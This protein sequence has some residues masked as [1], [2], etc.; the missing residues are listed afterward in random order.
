MDVRNFAVHFK[1]QC[2]TP[3]PDCAI[4]TRTQMAL[5]F[6]NQALEMN[7]G[8]YKHGRTTK[9]GIPQSEG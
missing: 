3:L 5:Y 6:E 2:F 9:E 8:M 7:K 4:L 1:I